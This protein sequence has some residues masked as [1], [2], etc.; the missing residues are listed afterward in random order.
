MSWRRAAIIQST[1]PSTLLSRQIIGPDDAQH[2]I[3]SGVG[4]TIVNFRMFAGGGRRNGQVAAGYVEENLQDF[5]GIHDLLDPTTAKR[6]RG[7]E[8]RDWIVNSIAIGACNYAWGLHD[9]VVVNDW[10]TLVGLGFEHAA[11]FA[12]K[13][14]L[15]D[16]PAGVPRVVHQTATAAFANVPH[17]LMIVVDGWKKEV[18]WFIDSVLVDSYVPVVPLDQ[19]GGTAAVMSLA[20]RYRGLV[21][22]NG[23]MQIKFYGGELA[24]P[25]LTL[26]EFP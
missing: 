17:E 2:T 8:I 11:D 21:P 5:P 13:T 7:F 9:L 15:K 24:A 4:G 16:A 22:A 19:M 6:T 18:R 23:D 10:T 12:L 1:L 3:V 14:F 25:I 26:R 20:M